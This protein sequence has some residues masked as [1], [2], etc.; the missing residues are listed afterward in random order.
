MVKCR[1]RHLS[2]RLLLLTTTP[3]QWEDVSALDR[4]RVHHCPIRWIFSSTGLELVAKPTTIRYL[5]HSATVV[6]ANSGITT[7][8]YGRQLGEFPCKLAWLR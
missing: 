7:H 8:T 2:W 4:Y 3:H 6:T 5:Y 1:G